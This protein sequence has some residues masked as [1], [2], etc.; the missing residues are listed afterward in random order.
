MNEFGLLEQNIS[1][2]TKIQKHNMHMLTLN[3]VV[4]DHLSE[5]PEK[6]QKNF[7]YLNHKRLRIKKTFLH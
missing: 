3:L 4:T 5:Q 1:I 6:N 7:S 2:A